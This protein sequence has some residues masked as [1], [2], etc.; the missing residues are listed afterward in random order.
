MECVEAAGLRVPQEIAIVGVDD[1]PIY[2]KMYQPL[3]SVK[4]SYEEIG[5]RAVGLIQE[6]RAPGIR[7]EQAPKHCFV[8]CDELV[9]R[10][11]SRP[12]LLGDE[13]IS[14]ALHFLHERFSEP[15]SLQQLAAV[16]GVSRT[17]FT[18]RFKSAVGD[19]PN[20]YLV[21]FRL[22]Q[23]KL[24]LSESMLTVSEIAYRVGFND[25]GYFARIFKRTCGV[26]AKE[27]RTRGGAPAV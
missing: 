9:V 18:L 12:R 21:D 26:T 22:Q 16:A 20:Q 3:S 17:T 5:R 14:R 11:S 6:W 2:T 7:R 25:P 27:F 15:L 10:Q 4:I 24:L 19:S 13:Q 23:A 8:P 1:H